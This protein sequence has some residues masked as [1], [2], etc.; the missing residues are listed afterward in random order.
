VQSSRDCAPEARSL[1]APQGLQILADARFMWYRTIVRILG[2][3]MDLVIDTSAI[4]AVIANEREKSS[5]IELT[6]GAALIAPE[7]V[8]WEVGN[9]FSAML[10]RGRLTFEQVQGAIGVYQKI[11]IRRVDVEL[12]SA[13]ELAAELDLYASDAYLIACARKQRCPLLTLDRGL[14]HAAKQAGI[15]I[16]EVSS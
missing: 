6:L 4:I 3:V 9:A 10:K 5:L 8:H 14:V 2:S 15:R 12:L 11:P 13:L 7:S 16:E 1:A